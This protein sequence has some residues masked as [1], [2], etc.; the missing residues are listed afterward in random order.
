MTFYFT[1]N[2]F[3]YCVTCIKI[4]SFCYERENIILLT[5]AMF[6][7]GC[8][9]DQWSQLF[10][11]SSFIP[12]HAFTHTHTHTHSGVM[13]LVE[14]DPIPHPFLFFSV[15]KLFLVDLYFYL[16]TVQYWYLLSKLLLYRVEIGCLLNPPT[17]VVVKL[18]F[19]RQPLNKLILC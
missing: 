17:V 12:F 14:T 11:D 2:I 9:K 1:F 16:V 5:F 4:F 15:S 3:Y 8:S 7:S 13:P 6:L 19:F 18:I 10:R